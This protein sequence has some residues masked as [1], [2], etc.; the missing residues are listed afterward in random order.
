MRFDYLNGRVPAAGYICSGCKYA[1]F[2]RTKA[3]FVNVNQ[4]R[5]PIPL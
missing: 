2:V 4:F 1:G 3:L 5:K